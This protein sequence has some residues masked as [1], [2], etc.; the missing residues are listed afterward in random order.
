M[1]GNTRHAKR[2]INALNDDKKSKSLFPC[3]RHMFCTAAKSAPASFPL[4][5]L[6]PTP[7]SARRNL[8]LFLQ[9]PS[10]GGGPYPG[11]FSNVHRHNLNAE[12]HGGC[13]R[14]LSSHAFAPRI[15]SDAVLEASTR[16]L[17]SYLTAHAYRPGSQ[18]LREQLMLRGTR[19]C[20]CAP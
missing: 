17:S 3:Y 11:V 19:H 2:Q 8:K 16:H 7:P 5:P 6:R 9:H 12:I 15:K 20:M 14:R 18:R 4:Q 1:R 13:G 10:P